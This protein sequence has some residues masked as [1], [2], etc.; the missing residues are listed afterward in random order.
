MKKQA[1]KPSDVVEST[2]HIY[3]RVSTVAQADKGTSLDSQLD[4]GQKR[5]KALKFKFLHWNEGGRSSHHEDIQGRPKLY[6]LFQAIKAG[7]VKH[8]WVYDQ[9]RLSRNDQVAS[10][11]RYELNKQGVTLYTKDGQ[12]DLSS[13][14]DKLLKQMLDAVA[15]F[16]NSV[17][18]ERSRMGKLMRVKAGFW[19]GGPPPYGYF[20]SAGKLAEEKNESKWVKLIFK[21]ALKGST[22][23]ALKQELDANGVFA[24]RG[25]LWSIGSLEALMKNT[26]YVGRYAFHDRVADE[27][28]EV[29]CPAIIDEVTWNAVNLARRRQSNRALQKNAT[30][31]NFYLLRDFMI[32]GHCGR[33]MAGRIKPLKS[34]YMYYCPNKERAWAKD[35]GS[36]TPWER[37]NGCGFERAMNIPATDKLVFETVVNLHRESS[38][39]KEEVKKQVFREQG[40]STPPTEAEIKDIARELRK[41]ERVFKNVQESIGQLEANRYLRTMED[42]AYKS[43]FRKMTEESDRLKAVLADLRRKLEGQTEKKQWVD[44][45]SQFG[46][47]LDE[48][49]KLSDEKRQQYLAGLIEKIE[50][51]FLPETRDH[52]LTIHFNHPIVGDKVKWKDPKKLSLGY[53]VIQGSKETPLR[54]EKRDA[55]GK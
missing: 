43:A 17:R 49:R 52:E 3:T 8:L 11:I 32:C 19:Q 38:V 44:W 31:T 23:P 1:R 6:E 53:A 27:K 36:A 55:R 46:E 47:E 4:L 20:L 9:S 12:F 2:L 5:A 48:K 21:R 18:A 33:K 40:I 28:V 13:P 39:L 50:C 25:G 51:R 42:A 14:S 30:T 26:H 29:H 7:E 16:E 41:Y 22:L 54:V 15:E 34:E 37:G 24:R 10:I 35:G 45:V